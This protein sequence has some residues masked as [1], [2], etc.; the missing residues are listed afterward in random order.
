[1][2]SADVRLSVGS[3]NFSLWQFESTLQETSFPEAGRVLQHTHLGRT[4]KV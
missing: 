4:K 3:Q 2:T 1:V